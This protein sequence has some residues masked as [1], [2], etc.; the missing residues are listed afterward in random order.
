MTKKPIVELAREDTAEREQA[1]KQQEAVDRIL[2]EHGYVT[3][4][5]K[6]IARESRD[7]TAMVGMLMLVTLCGFMAFVLGFLIGSCNAGIP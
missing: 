4:D 6:T 1:A 2:W 5:G 7:A 3:E